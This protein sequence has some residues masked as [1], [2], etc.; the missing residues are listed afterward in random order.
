[1]SPAVPGELPSAAGGGRSR[2]GP[3]VADGTG[4]ARRHAGHRAH[5]LVVARPP[6]T[7]RPRPRALRHRRARPRRRTAPA[8]SADA[9]GLCAVLAL[10]V[11]LAALLG[12]AV[13]LPQLR[14]VFA[15]R[16]LVAVLIFGT[17]T[18]ALLARPRLRVA[19][20]SLIVWLAAWLGWLLLSLLWAPDKTAGFRYLALLAL[21]VVV[22]AATAYWGTTR[23]RL[24]TLLV[25]LGLALALNLLVATAEGTLGLHLPSSAYGGQRIARFATG[26]FFN[27]ND[28]ATYLAMCLPFLLVG[29]FLTRRASLK[30]LALLG[31]A[32]SA[33]ALRP[34][35]VAVALV[36]IGFETLLVMAV[37]FARGWVRHRGAVVVIGVALLA[38]LAFLA[39]NGSQSL[40]LDQFQLV[41]V[42]Q[43]VESGSGSGGSRVALLRAGL[44]R[45]PAATTSPAR[46]RATPRAW[47]GSNPTDPGTSRTCTTGG[48]RSSSTAACP[49]SSSTCSST[50]ACSSPC[51]GSDATA[52]TPSCATWGRRPRSPSPAT[53]IGCWGPSSVFDFPPMWVL[54][55]LGL[56]V[57]LRAERLRGGAVWTT[58]RATGSARRGG[59]MKVLVVSHLYPSPGYERHLF[60]EDQVRALT[61]SRRARAR[62]VADRVRAAGAVGGARG[63]AAGERPRRA[64]CA[65]ASSW[66]TLACRCCRAC[67]SRRTPATSTTP[68]LRRSAAGAARRRDRPRARPPGDARRG[69]GARAR[70]G[71]RRALRRDRPRPRRA[72]TT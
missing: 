70:R 9:T 38:G 28:L 54:F 8:A 33:F 23:E 36:A 52:T 19:P 32:L 29:L 13:A 60:V 45:G 16:V 46:A 31:L 72:T 27:P 12:P 66:S 47:S 51:G 10:L 57:V 30:A 40:L 4:A 21:M 34:H 17:L 55:G 50:S 56:A 71:P 24:R 11:V 69:G 2:S 65:T 63:C 59:G 37:L 35:G 1:M 39:F 58:A 68:R 49:A 26:F 43:Q 5:R 15:F 42:T 53:S 3:K 64:R 41:D 44:A 20:L 14:Q 6:T 67:S 62:A 18:W 48:W 61:R 22:L 25:V 7:H